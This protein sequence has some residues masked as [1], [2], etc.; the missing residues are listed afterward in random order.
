M[1]AQINIKKREY[2]ALLKKCEEDVIK[3][4]REKKLRQISLEA[5]AALA[6]SKKAAHSPKN[7][8][9]HSIFAEEKPR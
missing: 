6:K 3:E 7:N 2:E 9:G 5:K 8:W 4:E 1:L